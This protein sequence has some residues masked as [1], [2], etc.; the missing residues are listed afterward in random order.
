MPWMNWTISGIDALV[1]G[2]GRPF[3]AEPGALSRRS[4]DLPIPEMLFGAMASAL[5]EDDAIPEEVHG[6]LLT[7]DGEVTYPLPYDGFV[8]GGQ[9]IRLVPGDK[10][11]G[12]NLPIEISRLLVK[13]EGD[14]RE[15]KEERD[16]SYLTQAEME[17]WLVD[18]GK[19][20]IDFDESPVS[21]APERRYG[22]KIQQNGTA[23]DGMLY[24]AESRRFGMHVKPVP[25]DV[26][27]AVRTKYGGN[28][29]GPMLMHLGGENRRAILREDEGDIWSMP[30]LIKTAMAEMKCLR[31]VLATP[32][33][34]SGSWLP[35]WLKT[36]DGGPPKGRVPKLGIEVELV[37]AAVGRRV[38]V[39]GWTATVRNH[40]NAHGPKP[41]QW[42]VPAGSVYFLKHNL[43]PQDVAKRIADEGWL[44][45]VSDDWPP[46]GASTSGRQGVGRYRKKGFGL[47][48][49]GT[50][51][52]Q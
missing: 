32:A 38:P 4:L 17:R 25:S 26:R 15:G 19:S 21:P 49:W 33:Y 35:A 3:T 28:K 20:S 6:P 9:M 11:K 36:H 52:D 5:G 31:L 48:L 30:G 42:C 22:V 8:S 10:A 12:C 23:E 51:N 7:N 46:P 1:F 2:D 37:S 18:D 47:A 34:F 24:S 27:I 29:T 44:Q 39:S 45:P 13:R 40:S 16:R 43:N 14:H 41:I 50:W